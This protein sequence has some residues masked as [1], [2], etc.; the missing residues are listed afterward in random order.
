MF[1]IAL[2][3]FCVCCQHLTELFGSI[4][5]EIVKEKTLNLFVSL[6][7]E[8]ITTGSNLDMSRSQLSGN[9]NGGGAGR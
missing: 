9:L 5:F 3:V 7:L 1:V 2:W 8:P 6:R 4:N